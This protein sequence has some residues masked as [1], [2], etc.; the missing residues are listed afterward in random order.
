MT[1]TSSMRRLRMDISLP[2]RPQER[3]PD[4][5]RNEEDMG[6]S[7]RKNKAGRRMCAPSANDLSS[8]GRRSRS[9]V[10][11]GIR[12]AHPK[13][14]LL[15]SSRRSV[16]EAVIIPYEGYDPVHGEITR[17]EKLGAHSFTFDRGSCFSLWRRI[18]AGVPMPLS[19]LPILMHR[20][21]AARMRIPMAVRRGL[22]ERIR[23]RYHYPERDIEYR[24]MDHESY[25]E[26]E[27]PQ[28]AYACGS[29]Q[30][31]MHFKMECILNA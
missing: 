29:I 18:R 27:M 10:F 30:G 2:S 21:S 7:V 31:V 28:L 1:R 17:K 20:G 23:F 8:T 11:E 22:P 19:T 9:P 12:C 15:G 4:G 24:G 6:R 25:Q 14:S 3:L 16:E 5:E 26:A 13:S